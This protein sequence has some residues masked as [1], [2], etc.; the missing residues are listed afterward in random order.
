MVVPVS[1]TM[2][3]NYVLHSGVFLFLFLLLFFFWYLLA[4]NIITTHNKYNKKE[5]GERK[6]KTKQN[7]AHVSFWEQKDEMRE[8][9]LLHADE[10]EAEL[11]GC[12]FSMG[13][14]LSIGCRGLEK[15][16]PA[17]VVLHSHLR[18]RFWII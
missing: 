16:E 8:R 13:L 15:A 4:Y 7:K 9:L 3:Y 1:A 10:T 14:L 11:E 6:N 12:L 17:M 18:P 5:L 2:D